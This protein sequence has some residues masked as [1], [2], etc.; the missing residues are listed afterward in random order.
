MAN[1]KD[2]VCGMEIEST[3]AAATSEYRGQTYYFCAPG[4]KKEFDADPA[5]YAAS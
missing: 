1:V 4:C 5:R 2:V 3:E